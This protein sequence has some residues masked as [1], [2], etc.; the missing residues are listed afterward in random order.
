VISVF[1][2]RPLVNNTPEDPRIR[3]KLKHTFYLMGLCAEA[4]LRLPFLMDVLHLYQVCDFFQIPNVID[5]PA[6]FGIADG[7]LSCVTSK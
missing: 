4:P 7:I 5:T 3:V 1:I 6:P 2:S